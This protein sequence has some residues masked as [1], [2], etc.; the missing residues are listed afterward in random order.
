MLIIETP[1]FTRRIRDVMTD[2][3]YRELQ[4]ALVANPQLGSGTGIA[5]LRKVRW[6][7]GG[8]GKSTS[9][10]IIYYWTRTRGAILML[11][12]FHKNEQSNL[13]DEQKRALAELVRR[14]FP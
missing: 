7:V 10:R 5:G 13:T 6:G 14:E 3:E 1:V 4:L 11:F 8:R 9:A 2:D 12:A